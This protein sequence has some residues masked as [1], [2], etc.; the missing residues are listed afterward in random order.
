VNFSRI[1]LIPTKIYEN[2]RNKTASKTKTIN[3][4]I[5][6]I[7]N[8]DDDIIRQ[9]CI[10]ILNKLDFK[11][12]KVFKILEN[13]LISDKNA[14][15]RYSAAKVIRT[16]FLNK[17]LIPFLWALQHESSYNCLIAVV[18]S[19]EE[20]SDDRVVSLL[21]EEIKKI[22][23]DKFRSSLQ[24]F[25]KGNFIE[26]FSH[27]ELAE[28]LI[29]HITIKYLNKKFA[30]INFKIENGL[31][32]E[33]DFSDVDNQ[34]MYWRDR[35]NLR[36]RSEIHGIKNL[37][38]L[39]KIKFFSLQWA[40]NNELSFKSSI[41]LI[42]ALE[43][44]NNDTA[45]RVLISQVKKIDDKRFKSSIRNILKSYHKMEN[46]SLSKLSTIFM[47]YLTILFLKKKYSS[48]KYTLKNGEIATIRIERE[49]LITIPE[50]IKYL[51]SLR[52]LI[53][54]ECSLHNL[55]ECIGAFTNL[56]V[57]DL[58]GNNLKCIPKSI[59]SLKSLRTLNLSKN[60]LQ[61]LPYSI[62]MLSSL[63]YL[64]LDNN[65]LITLPK[66]IGF[67]SSLKS[68][69]A[70]RNSLGKIPSSI[71][72]LKSLQS[73]NLSL[74][75]LNHLPQSIGLLYSL[76]YL[77][78]DNNYLV[79]LPNSIN[80][81]SSLKTLSLEEN[82]LLYL[83]GSI[84]QLKSL[85]ILKLG[86]NNLDKLPN[87]IG[88]LMKLRYLRLT[89]NKLHEFPALTCSLPLLEFLD[90]SRNKIKILP[91]CIGKF[92]SLK[93]LKLS[94]N[95]L[96]TLPDSISLLS[97]LEELNLN[98][99]NIRYLP[100][101]IGDVFSLKEIWLNGNKLTH[102]PKS[103]GKLKSLRK[104]NLKNNQLKTIPKSILN[105]SSLEEI[106]LNW[107]NIENLAEFDYFVK[108]FS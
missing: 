108:R 68:L 44:L 93:T 67:L 25:F 2:F 42:K 54:K 50:L 77:N 73:L 65:N 1:D 46:C 8:I 36:D 21:I 28:I 86:W 63:Q 70:E 104:L 56:K 53:L 57:L 26:Q 74:N 99:N 43:K 62:G 89:N 17:A 14:N 87:S 52:T 82:K 7:E 13:V 88:A 90:A 49:S 98:G 10:E 16:K 66:S 19:L 91:K 39:R 84:E 41:G 59:S 75:K 105:I 71:G 30:K 61:K 95:Q 12:N 100:N 102:L 55:P 72:A 9:E 76:E 15:L 85:E 4:L 97:I 92:K 38:Y 18:K 35:E 27:K 80:S 47:N 60:K 58:E 83:P 94:E 103:I 78:L 51:S 34:I 23:I 5:T 22:R 20:I 106:S 31:I 64:N 29:N 24:P 11:Q 79:N 40:I 45:K 6:L 107:E 32:V 96:E 37:K 48:I 81:I 101:S 69:S 33:L 3:L